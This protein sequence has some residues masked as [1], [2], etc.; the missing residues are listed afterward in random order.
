MSDTQ[1]S[2]PDLQVVD[3]PAASR[4]E[5]MLDDERVGLADYSI[6]GDVMTMPHVETDPAHQGQGFA[7][8]LM[9]GVI[10]SL[11]TNGQTIRPVC[12]YA[13]VYMRRRPETL[14]LLADQTGEQGGR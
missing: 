7:A 9:A 1:P 10:D 5:L 13:D 2:I 8:I 14:G 11:R 3:V 12:P 4:F 6:S